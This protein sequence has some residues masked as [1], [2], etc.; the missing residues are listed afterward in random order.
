MPGLRLTA[1]WDLGSED[2]DQQEFEFAVETFEPGAS[3][4]L[5]M[6]RAVW[7]WFG[8]PTEMQVEPPAE[9]S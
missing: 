9:E 6:P 4:T 7:E 3:V 8:K 5:T 1:S 2:P